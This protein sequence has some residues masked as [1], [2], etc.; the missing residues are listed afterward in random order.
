[1]FW[2]SGMSGCVDAFAAYWR[3]VEENPRIPMDLEAEA[4]ER[5]EPRR[6]KERA[7]AIVGRGAMAATR[8]GQ[9]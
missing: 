6:I 7:D 2:G 1:M 4:T 9:T 3:D 8:R 5:P